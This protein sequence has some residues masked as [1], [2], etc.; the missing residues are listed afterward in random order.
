M[1]RLGFWVIFSAVLMFSVDSLAAQPL[2]L[3]FI[4]IY[5]GDGRDILKT[6]TVAL[7]PQGKMTFDEKTNTIV[8]LER[9]EYLAHLQELIGYLDKTPQLA[10][11]S[12]TAADVNMSFIEKSGIRA[13]QVIYPRATYS[14]LQDML[15]AGQDSVKK[16]QLNLQLKSGEPSILLLKKDEIFPSAAV[17]PAGGSAPSIP[18]KNEDPEYIEV[19]PLVNNDDTVTLKLRPAKAG[20]QSSDPAI[21]PP[22]LLQVTM[23]RGDA[24]TLLGVRTISEFRKDSASR[25][26]LF[27]L[28]LN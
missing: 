13:V 23:H 17:E 24:L 7:S 3:R 21:E 14:G 9:E 16:Y 2:A 26:T 4:K 1:K 12:V 19:L 25:K 18:G 11:I 20:V 8:I 5:H 27:F 15:A 22:V 28:T 6:A 10:V